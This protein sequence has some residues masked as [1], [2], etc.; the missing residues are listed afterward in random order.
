YWNTWLKANDRAQLVFALADWEC[1]SLDYVYVNGERFNLKPN[2]S[3][4]SNADR[5]YIVDGYDDS[6][7]LPCYAGRMDQSANSQLI[8]HAEPSG[9]WTTSDRLAGICYV[10]AELR[11]SP[12]VF[13]GGIPELVFVIKGAKL[14]DQRKDST[15]GG[16]G[17]HRW[18]DVST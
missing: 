13:P 8:A 14:Y 12:D 18:N 7:I 17:S 5:E 3:P 1:D 16:S 11:H 9:R 6:I 2:P 4:E 10:Q 15:A